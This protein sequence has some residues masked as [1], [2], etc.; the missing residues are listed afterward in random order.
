[1]NPNDSRTKLVSSSSN[2]SKSLMLIGIVA[3]LTVIAWD[4]LE[5]QWI[6]AAFMLVLLIFQVLIPRRFS[7]EKAV[8]WILVSIMFLLL[9]IQV[10]SYLSLVNR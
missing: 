4:L 10:W 5:R 7:G 8:K 3:F 9:T 2:N 1:M 6:G